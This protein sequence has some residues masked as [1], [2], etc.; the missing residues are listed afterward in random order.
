MSRTAVTA[1]SPRKPTLRPRR[2]KQVIF[3]QRV[4]RMEI[5]GSGEEVTDEDEAGEPDEGAADASGEASSAVGSEEEDTSDGERDESPAQ[6]A[7]DSDEAVEEDAPGDDTF[8]VSDEDEAMSIDGRSP[9]P[10]RRRGGSGRA[11]IP[12][13]TPPLLA[14]SELT[15]SRI[16]MPPPRV[17]SRLHRSSARLASPESDDAQDGAD[18]AADDDEALE[19][20]DEEE[21]EDVDDAQHASPSKMRKLRN[22]KQLRIHTPSGSSSV[23]AARM[24]PEEGHGSG[25]EAESDSEAESEAEEDEAEEDDP[26]ADPKQATLARLR[27]A[28]L[29]E[30]CEERDI[31][32]KGKKAFLI[33]RLLQHHRARTAA[34]APSSQASRSSVDS[35]TTERPASSTAGKKGK[36]KVRPVVANAPGRKRSAAHVPL[37]LRS[38]S[39]QTLAS[40][41]DSPALDPCNPD[42]APAEAVDELNGLD[43][44]SLNLLDKEIPPHRLEKL[45][46][47]GSGGFK[48]V[49]VGKYFH[50]KSRAQKV[51]IADIRDDLTEM[52]IKELSLLRDLRHENIVRFI[53]VSIPDAPRHVPCMIV[54]ELCT[55]GD[56]FDYIRNVPAPSNDDIVSRSVRCL[57]R[58]LTPCAV[59]HHARDGA[60]HRVPARPRPGHHPPRHQVDEHPHHARPPRQDQRLCAHASRACACHSC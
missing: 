58:R 20:D 26:M 52:D 59:P 7:S 49:Y 43:L 18:E 11:T 47:I 9:P 10:P 6:G 37:L 21:D 54:S 30:L 36:G 29:A 48:D 45:E 5:D 57:S 55:N 42:A 4:K 12:V 14:R 56:L 2:A 15:R 8:E 44:E 24:Q 33:D 39:R 53:G 41:P 1:A 46:K 32:T 13:V 27:L 38:H 28:R 16:A 25:G 23:R 17:P 60:R 40:K 35:A 31:D 3:S 34:A 19:D 50:Q 51:A 22:G